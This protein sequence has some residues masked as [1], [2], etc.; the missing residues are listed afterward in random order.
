MENE[1]SLHEGSDRPSQGGLSGWNSSSDECSQSRHPQVE[2]RAKLHG[3][4]G[5]GALTNRWRAQGGRG[6]LE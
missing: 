6:A 2:I 1:V 3:L 5:W 4:R